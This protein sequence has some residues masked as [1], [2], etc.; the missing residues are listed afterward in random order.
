L[1]AEAKLIGHPVHVRIRR[2][3]ARELLLTKPFHFPEVI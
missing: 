1:W 3:H 2:T